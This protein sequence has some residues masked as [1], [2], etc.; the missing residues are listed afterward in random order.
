MAETWGDWYPTPELR[1]RKR[2]VEIDPIRM[3]VRHELVL[4]QKWCRLRN[5]MTTDRTPV[6]EE[7]RD[8][9]TE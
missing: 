2:E 6:N 5:Q 7:W 9:P 4:Q 1:F 8:V 3:V